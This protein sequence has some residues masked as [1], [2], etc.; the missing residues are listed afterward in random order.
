MS[1]TPIPDRQR[2]AFFL[3]SA[4]GA[5]ALAEK[6]AGKIRGFLESA[7]I[8][9]IHSALAA[10]VVPD[11]VPAL[12][13]AMAENNSLGAELWPGLH[14]NDGRD[15]ADCSFLIAKFIDDLGI[16]LGCPG[17]PAE[18]VGL[19]DRL[20]R[21]ASAGLALL[22]S[23]WGGGE[24]PALLPNLEQ[25]CGDFLGALEGAAEGLPMPCPIGAVGSGAQLFLWPGHPT[26]LL[27]W[28]GRK[29]TRPRLVFSRDGRRPGA[30][31]WGGG[32]AA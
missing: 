3:F 32:D 28:P 11:L 13:G 25:G 21:T 27:D 20:R 10:R 30:A 19:L 9:L 15:F 4:A 12:T 22:R 16:V 26:E 1:F 23:A 5:T 2:G 31:E 14:L 29:I 6:K 24:E 7:S 17:A 8:E 18:L